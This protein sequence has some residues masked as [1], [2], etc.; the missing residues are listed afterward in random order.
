MKNISKEAF[1]GIQVFRP[2]VSEQQSIAELLLTWDRT[3]RD[4]VDLIVAKER[5]K[6]GLIQQ[7]LVGRLRFKEFRR[8]RLQPT[9]LSGLLSKTASA[10]SVRPDEMYREIG[11]RSHGRGIFHKELVSG[12]TLGN[13]RVYE[14]VPGC[15]TCNIVFAWERALAVT[16]D[17]EAGMIASHR[18]P[19]FLPNDKRVVA[20]FVLHY[21]LS[22]E[23]A[24]ALK[25]ASP[26]GAGRNRTLSQGQFLKTTI[27]LPSLAEQR[28]IVD[29]INVAAA[30]I[31]SLGRQL[32][33]LRKQKRGLMQQ[34]LTGQRRLPD[35]L[36]KKGAKR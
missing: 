13:K 6:K 15:L 29:F 1:L 9:Q 16:T 18:F 24:K 21:M 14:V 23:G 5:L 25:L 8:K 7:L 36:L 3:I 2:R 22:D 12:R 17:K 34:L 4:T 11:V 20:E 10:V 30:E 35:S 26:G 19:M 33:R 28:K 27:P 31:S 32:E